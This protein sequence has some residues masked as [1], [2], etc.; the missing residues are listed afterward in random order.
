LPQKDLPL[1]YN[2][3]D[4]FVYPSHF[5]GFGLPVL[6]A[7]AC[8]TPVITSNTS[9]LPEVA[10]DAGILV[11]PTN[12]NALSQAMQSVFHNAE[13][14]RQMQ[15]KGLAQAAKFN[16]RKTATQTAQVY[17]RVVG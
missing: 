6:E 4:L 1:W 15:K 7:M 10:G 8:G 14:T 13:L 16:W 2:A 17:S 12:T 11:S 9:S 3:A 5:E